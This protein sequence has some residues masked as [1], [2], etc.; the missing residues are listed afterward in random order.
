MTG[1]CFTGQTL[2]E[3]FE[4]EGPIRIASSTDGPNIGLECSVA[5][6]GIPVETG[7]DNRNIGDVF[8]IIAHGDVENSGGVLYHT[9]Q[10]P[11][12]Q[13]SQG[14]NAESEHDSSYVTTFN[15]AAP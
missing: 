4:G 9:D 2:K 11:A 1:T 15:P 13:Q 14:L 12:Q 10:V 8:A 6:T 3:C 7:A 5:K